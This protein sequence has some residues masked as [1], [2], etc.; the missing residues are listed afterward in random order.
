MANKVIKIPLA[1]VDG[2]KAEGGYDLRYR[3]VSKDGTRK[4][5]WS[6]ISSINF[7]TDIAF[8]QV[9]SFYERLGYGKPLLEAATTQTDPHPTNGY[10]P[11]YV[12][13]NLAPFDYNVKSSISISEDTEGILTYS[14]DPLDK[15]PVSPK[16]DVYLSY[17]DA[18]NGW[19]G[20]NYAGTTSS[21]S[22]SF[23]S[24]YQG[25]YVQAAVFLSSF[26][27]LDNIYHNETNF[28]SISS[29]FNVYRDVGAATIGTVTAK[30][31]GT[32]ATAIISS[33]AE[34]FPLTGWS[35]RRVYADTT[36]LSRDRNAF[37]EAKVTVIERISNTSIRVASNVDFVSGT[38]IYNVSLI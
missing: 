32:R 34:T 28:V 16:V 21:T 20:W 25:Q 24:P 19:G 30:T 14:W 23:I 26:P 5:E 37:G 36:A 8:G 10:N 4:S 9:Y 2:L 33:L 18:A 1:D 31:A 3:I 17:R 15:Y 11:A 7:Q 6:E 38:T 13:T 22:F 29:A 35:E 12:F 27:K